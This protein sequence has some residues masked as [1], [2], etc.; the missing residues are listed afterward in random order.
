MRRLVLI[1]CSP[2]TG[3]SLVTQIFWRHGCWI[4]ENSV[5]EVNQFGYASFENRAVKEAARNEWVAWK[6]TRE[7]AFGR[8]MEPT[9]D[10]CERVRAAVDASILPGVRWVFKTTPEQYPMFAQFDPRLVMVHRNE[11]TAV[12]SMAEKHP[13]DD[14]ELIR[15]IHRRRVDRMQ[16][17]TDRHGAAWVHTDALMAGDFATIEAAVAWCGLEYDPR[18]VVASIDPGKWRREQSSA[19]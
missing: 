19:A 9:R 10:Q 2:R 8:F 3:S 13:H 1:L 11:A 16:E 4:D 17:L 18:H 15:E 12:A 14:P 7:D 5:R 6:R